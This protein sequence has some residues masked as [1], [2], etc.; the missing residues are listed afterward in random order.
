MNRKDAISWVWSVVTGL[1]ASETITLA[2]LVGATLALERV[3]M[4]QGVASLTLL[5]AVGR[6]CGLCPQRAVRGEIDVSSGA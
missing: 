4:S 1:L 6:L 3:G 5:G 2:E